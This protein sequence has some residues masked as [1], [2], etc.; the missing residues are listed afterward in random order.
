MKRRPDI[1]II[2]AMKCATSTLHEQLALQPG[3]FMSEPKEPNFFS[4]D[5]EFARGLD[6][7]DG[8]FD[9]APEGAICGESSTHYTKLPTYPKTIERLKTY[10]PNAK[11]IYVVR[12]PLDRLVSQYIHEWTMR[13]TSEPIDQAIDNLPIL[14]EYSLYSMQL[15][16]FFETF[17]PEK[18]Q[19]VFFD[20]LTKQSQ[21]ELER[22]C[23]FIGYQGAPKWVDDLPE[24]NVSA[25]RMRVSPL[26]D[27]IVYSP[28]VT[29]IRKTL[30]PKGIRNKVKDLWSMK[31]RPNLS[32]ANVARLTALFDADLAI[33][34]QWLGIELNCANFKQVAKSHAP[35]WA[36]PPTKR[37]AE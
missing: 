11:F 16:P 27:K 2:G 12:H 22:V 4:N 9:E 33:L 37:V 18:I 24:Q 26:R 15:K 7:Y 6:W 25:D 28:V 34:G 19:L 32:E 35:D 17:G 8:L 36:N 10:V 5:E 29:A 21:K 23:Q 14:K 1:I 30:I 13:L 31:Q 20:S 3:I